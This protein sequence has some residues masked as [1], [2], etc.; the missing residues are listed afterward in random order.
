[1][2]GGVVEYDGGGLHTALATHRYADKACEIAGF[3]GSST[4]ALC[5]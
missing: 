5:S 2:G 4:D 3:G 1:M